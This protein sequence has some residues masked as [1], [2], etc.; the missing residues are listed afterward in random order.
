MN[1]AKEQAQRAMSWA[2]MLARAGTYDQDKP[3]NPKVR[4]NAW[5]KERAARDMRGANEV[6]GTPFNVL[7]KQGS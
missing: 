6:F 2:L 5:Q 4:N 3:V 1:E 7:P